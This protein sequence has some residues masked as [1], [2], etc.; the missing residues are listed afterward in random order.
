MTYDET[1]DSLAF[2]NSAVLDRTVSRIVLIG[3]ALEHAIHS[4]EAWTARLGNDIVPVTILPDDDG[5]ILTLR[6]DVPEPVDQIV[7]CVHDEPILVF[8]AA[9]AAESVQIDVRLSV[10]CVRI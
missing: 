6:A 8:P 7:F 9:V 5:V 3:R 4:P 10:P 2:V 1:F